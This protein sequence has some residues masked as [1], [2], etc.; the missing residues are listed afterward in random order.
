MWAGERRFGAAWGNGRRV[1]PEKQQVPRARFCVGSGFALA[2]VMQRCD[3]RPTPDGVFQ[4]RRWRA[5][6]WNTRSVPEPTPQR[7]PGCQTPR[8]ET[9]ENQPS[10]KLPDRLKST[11]DF[12][13]DGPE[14]FA[15]VRMGGLAAT[16][17]SR[18]SIIHFRRECGLRNRYA[19]G[20]RRPR[21]G[22]GRGCSP[23]RPSAGCRERRRGP[24]RRGRC[25]N[26]RRCSRDR[27]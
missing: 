10:R 19:R 11:N 12:L 15:V 7:Q 14:P 1:S 26:F 5:R 16:D 21:G 18:R 9:S 24:A 4:P 3:G 2:A 22:R 20:P 6:L 27:S 25:N 8:D 23:G 13:M 17:S